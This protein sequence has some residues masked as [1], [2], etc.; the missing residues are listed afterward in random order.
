MGCGTGDQGRILREM[1]V[2]GSFYGIDMS[3]R[4]LESARSKG[5]YQELKQCIIPEIPYAARTFDVV[6]SAGT[7]CSPGNAPPKSLPEIIRVTKS[8][9]LLSLSYRKNWFENQDSGWKKVHEEMLEAGLMKQLFCEV[10]NY[11]TTQ[12]ISGLYFVC[13]KC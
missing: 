11:I 4:M 1:G 13:Q 8:A 5:L 2:Q 6:I 3:A 12:N 9:G 10:D 7:L